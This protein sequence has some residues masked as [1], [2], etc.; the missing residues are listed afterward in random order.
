MKEYHKIQSVFKR[1][2]KTLIDGAWTLP[3]FEYLADNL[4]TLTEKVDGTNI[5][6]MFK[7]GKITFGGRTDNADIPAALITRLNERFLPQAE[8]MQNMFNDDVCLY[9]E[10]Y[11]AK[12]QNGGNYRQ[13]PDFVLF[14]VRIGDFWLQRDSIVDIA[15][16][17]SLDVVPIIGETTLKQAVE[18]VRGGIKSTW[19]DF[20]A[21]GVIAKPLVE[22]KT[23]NGERIITK[24]KC[25]DF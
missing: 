5:R 13:D 15:E 16:K 23:R 9:G 2:G 7:D 4:W 18:M 14:D 12:I 19:G 3:E 11:G 17:L 25:K 10:G 8:T 24:I 6:I 21:E 1:D 22:L 20:Q